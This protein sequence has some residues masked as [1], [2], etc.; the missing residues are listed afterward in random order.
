MHFRPK[1]EQ[2]RDEMEFLNALWG[3]RRY[4]PSSCDAGCRSGS[5]PYVS[6]F[7]PHTKRCSSMALAQSRAEHGHNQIA[8]GVVPP[9]HA[10]PSMLIWPQKGQSP[11]GPVNEGDR[12]FTDRP[13]FC[14]P[15]P[16]L[17]RAQADER[18]ETTWKLSLSVRG[19]RWI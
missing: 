19:T 2:E 13:L 16:E 6:I 15:P 4:A 10:L 14:P 3:V 8:Q 5:R 1:P 18:F 11:S 12:A 9:N 7:I 17:P